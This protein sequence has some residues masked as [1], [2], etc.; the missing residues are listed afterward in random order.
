MIFSTPILEKPALLN[1]EGKQPMVADSNESPRSPGVHRVLVINDGQVVV[2]VKPDQE[3]QV[4]R[5]RFKEKAPEEV[6]LR[7]EVDYTPLPYILP[8]NFPLDYQINREESDFNRR[9]KEFTE[10]PAQDIMTL[11]NWQALER[12]KFAFDAAFNFGSGSQTRGV[13]RLV[14]D[15][16]PG[17]FSGNSKPYESPSWWR[18]W[19]FGERDTF[20]VSRTYN[21]QSFLEALAETIFRIVEKK[22]N[23]PVGRFCFV[24]QAE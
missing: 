4:E 2:R 10:L 5:L 18:D 1:I 3:R 22:Q 15:V 21:L 24:L 19:S 7:Y 6:K 8:L 12:N 9:R 23:Y 14:V 13:Y 17:K 16:F 11:E 20:N